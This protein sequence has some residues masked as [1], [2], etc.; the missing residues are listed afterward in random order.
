MVD[1]E[2]GMTKRIDIE[3]NAIDVVFAGDSPLVCYSGNAIAL[4]FD[5]NGININ[6]NQ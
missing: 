5:E 3:P 2:E 1:L 4:D 6:T